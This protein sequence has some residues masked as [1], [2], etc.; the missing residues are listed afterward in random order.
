[1]SVNMQDSVTKVFFEFAQLDKKMQPN[2]VA[3]YYDEKT[4]TLR[5]GFF[6][7]NTDNCYVREICA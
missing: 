5:E 7:G 6:M 1:M 3:R 4:E 2:G